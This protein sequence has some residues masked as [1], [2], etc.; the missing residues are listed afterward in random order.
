M[1]KNKVR[2]NSYKVKILTCQQME[3]DQENVE[4][5]VFNAMNKNF[6]HKD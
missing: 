5:F 2:K 1:T 6:S 3:V 4:Q